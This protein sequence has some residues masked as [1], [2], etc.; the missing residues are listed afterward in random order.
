MSYRENENFKN[1]AENI[2]LSPERTY[3]PHGFDEFVA[4]IQEAHRLGKKVRAV[5]SGWSFSDIMITKDFLIETRQIR[6]ILAFSQGRIVWGHRIPTDPINSNSN[7]ST[8]LGQ[9]LKESVLNT[10]RKFAHVLAGTTI[11]ELYE[12][13]QN[14]YQGD[15]NNGRSAWALPT[16][17]GASGQT[18]AGVISTSTHGGDFNLPPIPDMVQAIHLIAP[19][20]SQHWIER[21]GNASITDRRKVL[22]NSLPGMPSENLHY[23]NN[24]FN[25]VLVS[26]GNMGIIYSY[27]IEVRDQFGL[28]E[29]L[30]TTSWLDI[31]PLLE[32][33]EIFVS[34][35]Y[36]AE[37]TDREW[38]NHHPYKPDRQPKGLSIFINPYRLSENYQSDP[39]PD[40]GVI[41]VTSAESSDID[42]TLSPRTELD[43]IETAEILARFESAD[44]YGQIK[45]LID[46]VIDSLRSSGTTT[47]YPISY[48]VLDTTSNS[49]PP[50]LSLEIVVTT[51]ENRHTQ[52][53]DRILEIFDDIMQNNWSRGI[54]AK[55]AGGINL[56]YTR[57]TTAFLGMQHADTNATERFCHIEII[58]LREQWFSGRPL[59]GE[60]SD[61]TENEMENITEQ[62]T[63]RF[64]EATDEF[65]ARMHWGQLS[66]T[67]RFDPFRYSHVSNWLAIRNELTNNGSIQTFE[68]DFTTKNI[69]TWRNIP[70]HALDIGVGADDSVFII[71]TNRQPESGD[72]YHLNGNRWEHIGG[73]GVHIAVDPQ[74]HWWIVNNSN[75]IWNELHGE[76]SGG[77]HD[78]GIGADG[79]VFIIGT[80]S[81]IYRLNGS[82]W[83]HIRGSGVRIAVDPQGHWWIVNN[84]NQIWSEVHGEM[85]GRARDIGIGADGSVYIIGTNRREDGD[86]YRLCGSDWIRTGGEGVSIAVDGNGKPWVVRKNGEIWT[87]A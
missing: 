3:A 5:G 39:N 20:G 47:G 13:L 87:L 11:K 75:K 41:L 30:Q 35:R 65:C 85:S 24:W 69:P 19:D 27:I 2:D 70:G 32:T 12:A 9:A 6:G 26:L 28:S 63:D 25:S 8:I 22:A 84:S 43:V 46:Q 56:R 80:N 15:N 21:S 45:S 16:M 23:D 50:I 49:K 34:T 79:S 57:S 42:G 72:I 82:R 36:S 38:I 86:V 61:Y 73:S 31:K 10:N 77:A 64:E 48:S 78:I 76:M 1:W 33:G 37:H 51:R 18:L 53:I 68:N 60:G 29:D 83:E 66:R 74:G 17:G 40:R 52:Y 7:R 44:Q 81:H 54:S 55:F 58:V 14:N 62:F 67:N 4:I 59:W 71:G